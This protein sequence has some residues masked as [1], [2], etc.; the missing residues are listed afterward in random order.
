VKQSRFF[1]E[2]ATRRNDARDDKDSFFWRQFWDIV[3]IAEET[4]QNFA[5]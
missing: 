5:E 2:I 3:K 4:E 1:Y